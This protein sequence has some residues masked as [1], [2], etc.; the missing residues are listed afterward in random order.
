MRSFAPRYHSGMKYVIG[1]D[2]AGRGPLAGP[3]AVGVVMVPEEML[4]KLRKMF[5]GVND[6]KQLNE[7]ERER[8]YALMREEAG[9]RG[10]RRAGGAGA[11]F[12]F[13]VRFA[14]ARSIDAKGIVPSIYGCVSSGIS[15]LAPLDD[16]KSTRAP[17]EKAAK[18]KPRADVRILLDGALRAP[19]AYA[20]ETVIRGDAIHPIISLA[21][22]AA[23][24]ERDRLMKRLAKKHPGYGFEQ[25]KGYGTKHH[26][27]T[28]REHGCCVIHR[29]T[30]LPLEL[31]RKRA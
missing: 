23:K 30:F 22:I 8:I 19:S 18:G 9:K 5:P 20:Q 6:S 14:S 26:Y 12:S 17:G 7:E 25:H 15:A 28:L 31:R 16:G 10:G 4:P 29:Q 1:V 3:V 2:E 11:R 13:C 24:V 27:D 21:S